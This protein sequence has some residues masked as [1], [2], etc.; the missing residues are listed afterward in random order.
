MSGKNFSA[1]ENAQIELIV[2][3]TSDLCDELS[4]P[5]KFRGMFCELVR[6]LVTTAMIRVNPNRR[7]AYLDQWS[8]HLC[9]L[10]DRISRSPEDE[11]IILVI[12]ALKEFQPD[13]WRGKRKLG[14]T[15]PE[16][17]NCILLRDGEGWYSRVPDEELKP[18][19]PPTKPAT[20]AQLRKM[21]DGLLPA[22]KV[23]IPFDAS[24]AEYLRPLNQNCVLVKEYNQILPQFKTC[25]DLNNENY[26]RQTFPDIPYE[27]VEQWL[28][29]GISYW[30]AALLVAAYRSKLTASPGNLPHLREL[31][32]HAK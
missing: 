5:E 2:H 15:V 27:I 13:D 9:Y 19:S 21:K 1:E 7:M 14:E 10:P 23:S 30:D 16:G 18:I 4:V 20:K 22:M 32:A 11:R 8:R 6:R 12:K 24:N 28:C 25:K 17:T 26:W 29:N 3:A 31:M